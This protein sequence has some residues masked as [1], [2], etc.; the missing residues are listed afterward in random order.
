[1][2][3]LLTTDLQSEKHQADFLM[4]LNAYAT[5]IMGGG[6]CIDTTLHKQLIKG[7]INTPHK[8]IVLAYEDEKPVAVANCFYGFSTF[9]AKPLLNIHD[10]A[11]VPEAREKGIAKLLLE[12]IEKEAKKAECCKIT[13]EVLEGNTRAKKIYKNFGFNN[14][15]LDPSAGKAVFLDKEI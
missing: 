9:K 5:D 15:E 2:I 10:F 14:Y 4:L 1:M 12:Y 13:L 3:S 6:K 8:L 7:L 11:V